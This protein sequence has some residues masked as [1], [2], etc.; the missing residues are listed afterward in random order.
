MTTLGFLSNLSPSHVNSTFEEQRN[1]KLLP[2]LTT[3]P[4]PEPQT[5][6]AEQTAE[7][8]TAEMFLKMH[9]RH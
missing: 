6:E 2:A 5:S 4:V 8:N 3:E 7:W 1:V 9:P